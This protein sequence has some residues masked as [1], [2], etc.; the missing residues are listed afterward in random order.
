LLLL[1]VRPM[2]LH[3]RLRHLLKHDLHLLVLQV[4]LL[5]QLR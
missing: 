5:Q 4:F 2:L 3:A 1:L